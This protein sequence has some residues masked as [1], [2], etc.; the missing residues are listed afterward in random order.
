MPISWASSQW[1]HRWSYHWYCWIGHGRS[2][3]QAM[4]RPS[5]NRKVD[6]ESKA[7]PRP[8]Q[9][10][11]YP[12]RDVAS[13]TESAM[14]QANRKN[15]IKYN[16]IKAG[17]GGLLRDAEYSEQFEFMILLSLACGRKW[18]ELHPPR[19]GGTRLKNILTRE[20]CSI[21]LTIDAT[22]IRA[23]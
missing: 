2:H 17:S 4:Q 19:H 10:Y 23:V 9:L 22:R 20:I 21:R 11:P 18:I 1:R 15:C 13:A 14:I 8:P 16:K 12:S 6:H 5:L 3:T 7:T